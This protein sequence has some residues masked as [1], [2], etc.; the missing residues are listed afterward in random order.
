MTRRSFVLLLGIACALGAWTAV[1]SADTLIMRN[2]TRISG[3]LVGLREGVFEFEE[4]IAEMLRRWPASSAWS[5]PTCARSNS[6]R[7]GP[8]PSSRGDRGDRGERDGD[9]VGRPRGLREREVMVQARQRSG[10][11][12]A[13]PVRNRQ[14]V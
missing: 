7:M 9:Q 10:P 2:G 8:A 1:T 4:E 13:F 3:R 11:T 6:I 14:M 5:R 12:P